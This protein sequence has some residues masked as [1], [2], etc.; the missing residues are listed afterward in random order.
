MYVSATCSVVTHLAISMICTF[1]ALPVLCTPDHLLCSAGDLFGS[2]ELALYDIENRPEM[3]GLRKKD[4]NLMNYLCS[5]QIIW[6]VICTKTKAM[7]H[8]NCERISV[9]I[10]NSWSTSMQSD[11]GNW[12]VVWFF[13]LKMVLIGGA[14]PY[15]SH[16][17]HRAPGDQCLSM[18]IKMLFWTK[19]FAF[20][21][22]QLF[23]SRNYII[24][25]F[26][27][28]HLLYKQ[29]CFLEQSEFL[30]GPLKWFCC[31]IH[32]SVCIPPSNTHFNV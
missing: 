31:P 4:T 32:Y 21:Y 28:F 26:L 11:A 24:S 5:K 6:I 23:S 12:D 16:S 15:L 2:L 25:C 10:I 19:Y 29:S 3:E 1:Y 18:P 27:G 8:L 20:I 14:T 30:E 22:I 7:G 9:E 17:T 13:F